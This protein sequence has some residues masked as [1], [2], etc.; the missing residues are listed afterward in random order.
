MERA[1]GLSRHV[2]EYP[3]SANAYDGLG[4]AY[5]AAGKN[6]IAIQNYKKALKIDR[7]NE[8]ANEQLKKLLGQR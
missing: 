5:A 2:Q 3:H 7:A 6:D 8:K 1:V 4:D